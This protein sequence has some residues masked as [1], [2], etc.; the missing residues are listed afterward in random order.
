MSRTR[1]GREADRAAGDGDSPSRGEPSGA[2][3]VV[4]V[5]PLQLIRDSLEAVVHGAPDLEV[6]ASV[7]SACEAVQAIE[8]HRGRPR[9]VALISL[10]LFG[11]REALWLISTVRQRF[12]ACVVLA[13]GGSL[14][15]VSIAA[16]LFAGAQGYVD[17]SAEPESL[18]EAVRRA[19]D[20]DPVL[21]GLP[22]DA[23]ARVADVLATL[24]KG[25]QLLTPRERDV[26]AAAGKGLTSREIADRLGVRQHT[27]A[28]H[29]RRIRR[30]LGAKNRVSAI[31]RAA[32]LGLIPTD[33]ETRYGG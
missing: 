26:I 20:G 27:V 19:G 11:R 22:P 2:T 14:D 29:L 31:G 5:E 8:Q 3:G 18:V 10:A 12:P 15:P 16:A 23:P 25:L 4:I 13:C 9:L 32:R 30:K 24:G 28:A 1:R 21:T 17:Q 6:V 7:G 33:Q